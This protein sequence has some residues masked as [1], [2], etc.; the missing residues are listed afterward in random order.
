MAR[1]I[2][3]QNYVEAGDVKRT[4]QYLFEAEVGVPA[5]ELTVWLEKSKANEKHPNGK[6]WIILPKGNCTNRAYF[7]EDLFNETQLDGVVDVEVKTAAP[8]VLGATG[9][10]QEVIKFLNETLAA[11]YTTLVNKALEAFKA[12]KENSKKKK[13][14][15]MTKE[16]LEAMIQALESGTKYAPAAAPKSFLDMFSEV[17]YAR[18]NE[19]LAISAA[20]KANAPKAVRAPLT[21]DQKAQRNAKRQKTE[22]SKAQALLAALKA[23][24]MGGD[25]AAP[26]T[27]ED[28]EEVDD[29]DLI[30]NEDRN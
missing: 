16:E 12:A 5:V 29:E 8:R 25:M 7:S 15:D 27:P 24:S 30:D 1:I 13:L 6:P 17:D 18:Y 26:V 2:R 11:E 20:N 9:A 19:L 3:N 22:L 10:K 23:R 21:D 14:E 28:E 4:G